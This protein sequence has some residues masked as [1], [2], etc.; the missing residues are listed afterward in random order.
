MHIATHLSKS[1]HGIWYY[2]WVVPPRIRARHPALPKELKRSTKT[3]DIRLARVRA[4][5]LHAAIALPYMDSDEFERLLADAGRH[6]YRVAVDPA[7]GRVEVEAEPHET[8]AAL[9]AVER[10]QE[11]MRNRIQ[12]TRAE[13]RANA[14]N[15][16]SAGSALLISVAFDKYATEQRELNHWSE[17]TLQYAHEPSVKLFREL[18]GESTVTPAGVTQF[19][20]PLSLLTRER[21]SDFIATFR[22]F[23]ERQG[24]RYANAREAI[25]E[26]GKRQ[27]LDNYFKRLEHINQFV[28]YCIGKGWLGEEAG[29]ELKN[30]LK[31][32]NARSRQAT[33]KRRVAE[34][35]SAS[36]GYVSFSKEELA[37]LFGSD[38][39][40]HVA[41]RRGEKW[42][43]NEISRA[44]YRYWTP[45]IALYSGLRVSEIGQLQV[46]DFEHRDGVHCLTIAEG[47]V[48]EPTGATTR[49]KTLASARTIPLHP[50]LLELG[51]LNYVEE[52]RRSGKEWLWDGLLWTP[53]DGFGKY[54]SRDFTLLTK[55][56]GVY[57]HRRKV[58]HSFRSTLQQALSRAA[59]D[60]TLID[61][62]IG[63]EVASE[64]HKS[65]MRT[66][67]GKAFPYEH[68]HAVLATVEY[69]IA[70]P[71]LSRLLAHTS[72]A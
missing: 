33:T 6:Q 43:P 25:A 50:K 26:G 17:N 51:L 67:D 28:R 62:F 48:A 20:L 29:D 34:G 1:R 24:K 10:L 49:L 21:L 14:P 7:T 58:F 61:Q 4:R 19:D 64:R 35:G 65:Y 68:V 11:L 30:I 47:R 44:T 3:A 57:A 22:S 66:D 72:P 71:L 46:Q 42:T 5:Q 23:P 39:V 38:F 40:A 56:V 16:A 52:R 2:R 13:L 63:H 53:K 60:G 8:E 69:D 15:A 59:L 37:K 18:V 9:A 27:S 32:N 41:L 12:Q 31:R 55:R 36:D 54:L 70:P 45:L